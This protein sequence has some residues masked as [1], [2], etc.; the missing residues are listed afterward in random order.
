MPLCRLRSDLLDFFKA[1]K[2]KTTQT[3]ELMKR[4]PLTLLTTCSLFLF[5]CSGE[6]NGEESAAESPFDPALFSGLFLA[7]EPA[8]EPVSVLEARKSAQPG[9]TIAVV[10]KI[11]GVLHPFTEGY[12]SA[13]LADEGLR[14]CDLIPGD[15]CPTPWDACC[16]SPEEIKSQRMTI[17]V[18]GP[19]GLP[20]ARGLKGVNGLHELNS[21]VVTGT[22]N[23]NSTPENLILDLTG[24]FRK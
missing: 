7:K 24:I 17:Q 8:E 22:V 5:S 4:I 23:E 19:E 3:T 1:T 21:L 15:E 20:V 12:A 9:E 10:G 2:L 11:A 14:T 13:V 6:K 16:A 18:P